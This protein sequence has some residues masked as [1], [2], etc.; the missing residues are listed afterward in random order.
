MVVIDRRE[1]R[2]KLRAA[3]SRVTPERLAEIVNGVTHKRLTEILGAAE[4]SAAGSGVLNREYLCKLM[5][6]PYKERLTEQ[7]PVNRLLNALRLDQGSSS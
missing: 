7:K 4:N 2:I 5:G 3:L 1:V 6:V